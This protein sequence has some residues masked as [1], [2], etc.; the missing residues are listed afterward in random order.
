MLTFW[1]LQSASKLSPKH[2]NTKGN[3]R[4]GHRMRLTR[5]RQ[6][7]ARCMARATCWCRRRQIAVR[8]IAFV[9]PSVRSG[10]HSLSSAAVDRH[11]EGGIGG[12][13]ALLWRGF[14]ISTLTQRMSNT[15]SKALTKPRL[16]ARSRW[17]WPAVARHAPHTP[18][19]PAPTDR[20]A[21]CRCMAQTRRPARGRKPRWM[22]ATALRW[23][24]VG[25]ESHELFGCI[26]HTACNGH[27]HGLQSLG[28]CL[29]LRSR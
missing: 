9:C 20:R 10:V 1:V 6:A 3:R 14:W 11:G 29:G 4:R 7:S 13:Q 18:G 28:D 23:P 5:L 15:S 26:H 25:V 27:R 16:V 19:A 17:P 21:M 24:T 12:V 8:L 2:R 22:C